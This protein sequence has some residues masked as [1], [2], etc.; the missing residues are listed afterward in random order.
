MLLLVFLHFDSQTNRVY[1]A[2]KVNKH[3]KNFPNKLNIN[4]HKS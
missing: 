1:V 3:A 2:Y 4:Q